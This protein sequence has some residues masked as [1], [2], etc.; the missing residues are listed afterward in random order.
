VIVRRAVIGFLALA[1]G[2]ANAADRPQA[3]IEGCIGKDV[4]VCERSFGSVLTKIED[5]DNLDEQLKK[6]PAIHLS[7]RALNTPGTFTLRAEIGQDN[8]VTAALMILPFIPSTLPTKEVGY[9][10]SGLYEA[11]I[12]LLGSSC[13][14]SRDALY[15]LFEETIKPTLKGPP[16]RSQTSETYFEMAKSIPICKHLLSYATLFGTDPYHF[17]LK[18][19]AGSFVFP[20]IAVQ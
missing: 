6:H 5:G 10:K 17:T 4:H 2:A 11:A 12:I 8:R 20:V 16:D 3:P 9:G 1:T 7:G 19:P 13:V 15:Q 14:Q 18:A